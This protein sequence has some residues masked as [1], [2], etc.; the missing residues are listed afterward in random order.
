MQGLDV[1][2]EDFGVGNAQGHHMNED[3]VR[4]AAQILARPYDQ[5]AAAAN[6]V[7]GL[8]GRARA[9][10]RARQQHWTDWT[11][12][13]RHSPTEELADPLQGQNEPGPAP[14]RVHSNAS[15]RYNGLASTRPSERVLPRR[16]HTDYA[17][18]RA[19][20]APAIGGAVVRDAAAAAGAIPTR[21]HSMMA[22]LTRRR[23][24]EG[25][26]VGAWLQHVEDGEPAGGRGQSSEE[27]SAAA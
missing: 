18:E 5:A 1:E 20:H 11:R 23:N 19:R 17:S 16:T 9:R 22:G 13:E 26:R 7:M 8:G 2:G 4:A 15:R 12:D 27:I 24:V 25:G 10:P 14:L 6:E 21:R 3:Y